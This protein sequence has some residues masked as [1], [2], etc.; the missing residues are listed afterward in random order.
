MNNDNTTIYITCEVCEGTYDRKRS[1]LV[2]S[3]EGDTP[4][5]WQC[6]VCAGD[7]IEYARSKVG[8]L[9][10]QLAEARSRLHKYGEVD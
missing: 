8:V 5:T 6:R 9:Q 2:R 7:T 3:S 1:V 10:R 4:N